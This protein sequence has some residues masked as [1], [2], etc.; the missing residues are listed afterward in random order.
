MDKNQQYTEAKQFA[1]ALAQVITLA[2]GYP[3][4][5]P[6]DVPSLFGLNATPPE[7]PTK[8]D[9]LKIFTLVTGEALILAKKEVKPGEPLNK[10]EVFKL[11][12]GEMFGDFAKTLMDP[13][14]FRSIVAVNNDPA[15]KAGY[16]Q[17]SQILPVSFGKE[18]LSKNG[19][20]FGDVVLAEKAIETRAGQEEYV[21]LQYPSLPSGKTS[22][23]LSLLGV[24]L[25]MSAA[26]G[27]AVNRHEGTALPPEFDIAIRYSTSAKR[28]ELFIKGIPAEKIRETIGELTRQ[29]SRNREE[30][31]K[32]VLKIGGHELPYTE[33]KFSNG[34]LTYLDF[35]NVPVSDHA[36]L[37]TILKGLTGAKLLIVKSG[38]LELPFNS[39]IDQLK[40]AVRPEPAIQQQSSPPEVE[41]PTGGTIV[42]WLKAAVNLFRGK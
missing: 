37:V 34:N 13:G 16:M 20:N 30:E 2:K 21:S 29:P 12:M 33:H 42:S 18:V 4:L 38:E 9:L 5:F 40:E 14:A 35:S 7:P 23:L 8:E 41:T 17:E 1:V 15:F 11:A 27:M 24:T 32:P 19:I 3:Q 22:S 36:G 28:P 6:S 10:S 31:R 39:S 25:S 26:D